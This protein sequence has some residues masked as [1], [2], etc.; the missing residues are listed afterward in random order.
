MP[1]KYPQLNDKE[2]LEEKYLEERLSIR[3][4]ASVVGCGGRAVWNALKRL[5]I[6][7]RKCFEAKKGRTKY[8]ELKDGDWLYQKYW[9]E[10]LS[11]HGIAA[12]I[13]CSADM[14]SDALRRLGI[15]ARTLFDA[16]QNRR[17]YIE[18]RDRE[19]LEEK[20][21][22]EGLSMAKIAGII[23]CDESS[24]RNALKHFGIPI[25]A[26]SE[27]QSNR[28]EE[29]IQKM[30]EAHKGKHPSEKAR[31]K[32]SEAAKRHW[33]DSDYI[34][35]VFDGLNMKPNAQEK[36]VG[37]ILQKHVPDEY[38]YN[39]DFSCG[40]TIGG[41]IPDFVNVNGEKIVIEVFGPWHDEK[42]MREHF[43]D[44]IPWKRTEFGTKAI[45]SQFG[46]KCVVLWQDDLEREDA[47]DFVL[48][49]LKEEKVI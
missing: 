7:T 43:G 41:K 33:Q 36:K 29:T 47:D 11:T 46:F 5:K 34:K 44:N 49:K 15:P 10:G 38:A 3:A 4:I 13:G 24:V 45:Y 2:W 20:Y 6:P 35:K 42:Y 23:G 30:R 14:V 28:S 25:R 48:K 12:I 26:L 22:G 17:P 27:A 21:W 18:L 16:R 37:A 19:W 9:E 40:I 31:Q 39:G 8:K 32:M 1:S